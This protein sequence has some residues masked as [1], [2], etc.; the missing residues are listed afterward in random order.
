MQTI[1]NRK[2]NAAV[3]IFVFIQQCRKTC[4]NRKLAFSH[5]RK[6]ERPGYEILLNDISEL[7]YVG[8]GKKYGV[9]D[10]AIRKWIR[11]YEKYLE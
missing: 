5:E 9:S 10:N 6:V 8:T 11:F 7:G 2:K 4:S 3:I 1:N